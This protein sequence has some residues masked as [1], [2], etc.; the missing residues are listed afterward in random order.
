MRGGV[1]E[2]EAPRGKKRSKKA[3][4]LHTA[5]AAAASSHL[6]EDRKN[7]EQTCGARKGVFLGMITGVVRVDHPKAP[8]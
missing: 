3:S 6:S 7:L 2:L 8:F 5:A 1:S 4:V